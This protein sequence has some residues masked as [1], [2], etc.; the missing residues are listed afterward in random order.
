MRVVRPRL[1]LAVLTGL[2]CVNYLDRFVLSGVLTP[3]KADLGL[4]DAALGRLQTAFM[5]G[6]FVTAPFFGFLGDRWLRKGLIA[7]GVVVWS[8]GTFLSGFARDAQELFWARVLVGVGEASYAT[9]SPSLIADAFSMRR[10]NDAISIFYVAIPVGAAL[11]YL[12]GGLVA[13]HHGWRTAFWWAGVPGLA[14]VGAL[15]WL[16]EPARGASEASE[17]ALVVPEAKDLL[18]LWRLPEYLRVTAGYTAYTF[19]MGAYGYWGPAFLNR[20][21]GVP[22]EQATMFFSLLLVL[23][24]LLG[25]LAGGFFA[26]R[27]AR[28][29]GPR[30]YAS[31]CAY[32]TLASVPLTAAA[33]ASPD[34]LV[35]RVCLAGAI[36][37]VFLGT[38]PVNTWAFEV[39]PVSLRASAMAFSILATHL[40][41]DMWSPQIVGW[42]SDHWGLRQGLFLLPVALG[43]AA[44]L[45]WPGSFRARPSRA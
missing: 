18:K 1:L 41:G 13:A 35:A 21:H 40:L 14:L 42:L 12:V 37:L 31:V 10:R 45:W 25:T 22:N 36:F 30:A 5:I 39:V 44:L 20:I 32:S 34:L 28:Q 2:N 8:A 6:Y 24:G 38:G 23:G 11:G 29:V 9:I 3:L 26:T 17:K 43:T 15:L 7:G 33:F 19:A 4:T 16:K 27:W